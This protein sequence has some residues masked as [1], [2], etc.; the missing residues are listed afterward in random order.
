MQRLFRYKP[1]RLALGREFEKRVCQRSET[2]A[3]YSRDK[4][5][6]SN[7][8]TLDSRESDLIIEGIPDSTLRDQA[9]TNFRQQ[10][11]FS[12]LFKIYRWR[13]MWGMIVIRTR[14]EAIRGSPPMV[15]K[16]LWCY[17]CN[18]M[19]HLK[20]NCGKSTRQWGSCY[21]CG[22]ATHRARNCPQN[23][24]IRKPAP[25]SSTRL[26]QPSSPDNPFMVPVEF[27]WYTR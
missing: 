12:M 23:V 11:I 20:T 2:F 16:D 17:N 3:D 27:C 25:Q 6:L 14:D 26:L 1:N 18:E 10:M 7:R 21:A 4:I 15:R 5:T 22:N 13:S 9:K 8:F 24:S 19:E